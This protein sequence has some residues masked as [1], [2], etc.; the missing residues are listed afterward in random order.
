MGVH[1]KP[2]PWG[3]DPLNPIAVLFVVVFLGK[4]SPCTPGHQHARG[5]V[6]T[7]LIFGFRGD[8]ISLGHA[9]DVAAMISGSVNTA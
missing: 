1:L 3:L 6:T 2:R 8:P 5:K 9:I 7:C 4:D